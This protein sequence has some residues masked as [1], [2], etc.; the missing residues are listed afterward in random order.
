[1]LGGMKTTEGVTE[2][3]LADWSAR[4]IHVRN[5]PVEVSCLQGEVLVTLEGDLDDHVL[6]AGQAFR[7]E[8]RGRLVVAALGP[9]RVRVAEVVSPR[10]L[11]RVRRRTVLPGV[12]LLA[13]FAALA[14]GF[15]G[16]TSRVRAVA[17][18]AR[19][20][21]GQRFALCT[22]TDATIAPR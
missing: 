4:S 5:Q 15:F 22:C 13:L 2:L 14:L 6:A 10:P 19:D 21:A 12:G 7:A 18:A 11:F 16:E 8:R 20:E 9:S 3:A 1:M 17:V